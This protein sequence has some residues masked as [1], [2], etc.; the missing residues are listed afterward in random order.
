M[1]DRTDIIDII[2]QEAKN[3]IS[4]EY[5]INIIKNIDCNI[6]DID[7][8]DFVNEMIEA[9]LLKSDIEIDILGEYPL[10]NL[11]NKLKKIGESRVSSQLLNIE[12]LLKT[13]IQLYSTSYHHISNQIISVLEN[14]GLPCNSKNLL[15]VDLYKPVSS[16]TISRNSA[17]NLE[18]LL[19]LLVRIQPSIT[20]NRIKEFITAFE[21]KYEDKEIE[22]MQALDNEYGIGYPVNH[23]EV[24]DQSE[25]LRGLIIPYQPMNERYTSYNKVESILLKKLFHCIKNNGD[26]VYIN[27]SDFE[28]INYNG[29]FPPTIFVLCSILK[30][31]E[32]FVKAI[33]G[34]SAANIVSRFAIGN[35]EIKNLVNIISK[36]E[37]TN[38]ADNMILAEVAHI[39]D[40]NDGN[41]ACQI[42]ARNYIIPYISNYKR[43]QDNIIPISDI[44]ISI[45]EGKII[46]KSRRLNKQISPRYT[47]AYNYD[48][49][50]LPAIRFLYDMQCADMTDVLSCKWNEMLYELEYLPR[51]QYNNC[52]LSKQRWVLRQEEIKHFFDKSNNEWCTL[53]NNYAATRGIP[54]ETVIIESDN[55]LYIN[56]SDS[57]DCLL[58]K[59]IA[60]KNKQLIIEEFIYSTNKSIVECNGEHYASETILFFEQNDSR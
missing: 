18:N 39:P 50:Q 31:D 41:I 34:A 14:L 16:A 60:A 40:H 53:I 13:N 43:S 44:T 23:G 32:I 49:S 52:I 26:T 35:T 2:L 54:N 1:V 27:D 6:L 42:K 24:D 10:S 36:I 37:Q 30:D 9:Q 47:S 55:E 56:L 59:S 11:I 17:V 3:G 45:R 58:L 15:N 48:R 33:G 29:N 7:A 28:G 57:Q 8:R 25:L 21:R 38:A 12:S 19:T 4:I 20:N 5:A 22:L 51:I 46:L